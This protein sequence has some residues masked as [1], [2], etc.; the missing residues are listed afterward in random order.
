MQL[1]EVLD[2]LIQHKLPFRESRRP[3]PNSAKSI[4]AIDQ[5]VLITPLF[6]LIFMF[7]YENQEG[8]EMERKELHKKFKRNYFDGEVV[9]I[10]TNNIY[11]VTS[12]H[13]GEIESDLEKRLKDIFSPSHK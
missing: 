6:N 7:E 13:K 8:L 2:L 4:T 3:I 10:I 1:N 5:I 12:K 9:E 11:I